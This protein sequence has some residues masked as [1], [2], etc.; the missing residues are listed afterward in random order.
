MCLSLSGYAQTDSLSVVQQSSNNVVKIEVRKPS[1]SKIDKF[2]DDDNFKYEEEPIA[3]PGFIDR[4]LTWLLYKIFGNINPDGHSIKVF[5]N[6]II[7]PLAVIIIIFAILKLL[8]IKVTGIFGRK[9]SKVDL[10][11]KIG[12]EDVRGSEFDELLAKALADKNYRLAVRYLYLKT[13]QKL[14][15]LQLITWNPNKTNHSYINELSNKKLTSSFQEKVFLFELV[16]YGEYQ[17]KEIEFDQIQQ[18][19]I[20]FNQQLQQ[21]PTV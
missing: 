11:F 12:D 18:A 9:A 5:W 14:D 8:G 21:Q 4:F 13:L 17:I 15:E 19:F 20:S 7:I 6:F 10:N 3:S 2:S 1:Q 16:W